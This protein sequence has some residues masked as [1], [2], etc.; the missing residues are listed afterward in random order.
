MTL[1]TLAAAHT[2]ST[3]SPTNPIN[4]KRGYTA[5]QIGPLFRDAT[6][7]TGLNNLG[8]VSGY[9]ETLSPF[10]R[11]GWVWTQDFAGA[12]ARPTGGPSS[13][14]WDINDAGILV[15]TTQESVPGSTIFGGWWDETGLYHDNTGNW[16]EAVAIADDPLSRRAGFDQRNGI[17]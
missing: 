15:G 2:L 8:N 9:S 17:T 10:S 1:L 4:P 5:I 6:H 12:P 7:P 16:T 3:A 11:I 14:I 13:R